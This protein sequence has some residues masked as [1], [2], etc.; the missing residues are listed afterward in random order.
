MRR[1][2]AALA[3][4]L[5]LA[6]GGAAHAGP[7][8]DDVSKCLAA[9]MNDGDRASLAIWL[10]EE[11]SA[12]PAVKSMTSVTEGQRAEARKA[13]AGLVQRLVTEDCRTQAAAALRN[14]GAGVLLPPFWEQAQASIGSLARDPTVLA[15]MQQIGQYLDTA[16]IVAAMRDAGAVGD[17]K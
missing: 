17:K 7:Y 6:L 9:K 15:N 14:E 12:N 2:T 13:V 11:M 1:T 16:K 4:A 5:A 3:L 10:F 8:A